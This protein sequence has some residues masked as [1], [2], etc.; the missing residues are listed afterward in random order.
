MI[1]QLFDALSG[2]ELTRRVL[3]VD[4]LFPAAAFYL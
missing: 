3:L 1:N 2:C 4:S